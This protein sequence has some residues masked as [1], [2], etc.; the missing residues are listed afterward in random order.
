[1]NVAYRNHPALLVL[2]LG[3]MGCPASRPALVGAP[4]APLDTEE[5][6]WGVNADGRVYDFVVRPLRWQ[7]DFHFEWQMT[8]PTYNTGRATVTADALEKCDRQTNRFG[9]GE[10]RIINGCTVVFSRPAFAKLAA[11]EEVEISIDHKLVS[12]R[13]GARG[14]YEVL[15]AGKVIT[16][17]VLSVTGKHRQTTYKY[18]LLDNPDVP[19]IVR[20]SVGFAVWLTE[21]RGD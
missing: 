17:P 10:N 5:L 11:G 3:L 1:M 18:M 6:R 21:A 20:Q 2:A 9:H 16:I 15:R 7:P 4:P 14:T 19:L 8:G 12:L 13:A